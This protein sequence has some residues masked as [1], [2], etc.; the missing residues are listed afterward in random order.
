MSSLLDD[1]SEDETTMH[2]NYMIEQDIPPEA[3]EGIYSQFKH[4]MQRIMVKRLIELGYA[5]SNTSNKKPEVCYQQQIKEEPKSKHIEFTG[6]QERETFKARHKENMRELNE[7][8]E[9]W[10][11]FQD[12][13]GPPW[14]ET[15]LNKT[16]G[17]NTM[18]ETTEDGNR[19]SQSYE[20]HALAHHFKEKQ[21]EMI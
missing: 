4:Q 13:Q 2:A 5:G 1:R 19:N 7:R 18:N 9:A 14:K 3:D 12:E 20:Q 6:E 17:T 15:P 10:K 16:N 8:I 21:E 11:P